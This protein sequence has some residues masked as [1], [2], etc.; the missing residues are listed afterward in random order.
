MKRQD[1]RKGKG[2]GEGGRDRGRRG[3][4][5]GEIG[6]GG[7]RVKRQGSREGKKKKKSD[8]CHCIM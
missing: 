2:E 4:R 3:K 6:A 1:G 5:E 8:T 7:G